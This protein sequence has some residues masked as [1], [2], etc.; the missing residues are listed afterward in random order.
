MMRFPNTDK[1]YMYLPIRTNID[2]TTLAVR[3][4]V[5]AAQAVPT[6][7]LSADWDP[8]PPTKTPRIRLFVDMALLTAGSYYTLWA[9]ITAL[10]EK[11]VL[12]S[13]NQFQVYATS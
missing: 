5:T 9:E 13:T 2:P 10:P 11:P 7:W 12:R 4:A 6:T 3:A 8:A 1:R